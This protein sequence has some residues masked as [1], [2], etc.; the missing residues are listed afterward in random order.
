MNQVKAKIKDVN[1]IKQPNGGWIQRF[2]KG[3]S[4]NPN[5]RPKGKS[6]K[7]QLELLINDIVNIH[8]GK[9]SNF[10][11][12]VIYNLYEIVLADIA[13]NCVTDDI[14]HLYF[15][16][17]D[18]GIKIGISKNVEKRYLQIKNYAGDIKV[19]KVINYAGNFEKNIHDK[20]KHLNIRDNSE[21][22]VEWFNKD[23]ELYNFIEN[24][25]TSKQLSKMFGTFT[26]FQ[27]SLFN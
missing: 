11:K 16:E 7:K 27:L 9:I 1:K 21:I 22:G 20:F 18:F 3:V 8:N 17:S 4:G 6:K 23:A 5:G 14:Q 2:E 26:E 15:I 19:L 10:R 13:T 25:N 12:K 24:I